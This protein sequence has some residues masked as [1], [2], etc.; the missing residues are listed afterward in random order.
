MHVQVDDVRLFFDTVGPGLR[1]DGAAM[2]AVP[3]VI[4]LHGG[5]GLDHSALRPALDVLGEISQVVYLDL[6][7]HGRSDR[8]SPEHWTLQRWADDLRGFCAALGIERPTVLGTSFGGYVAMMFALRYP[9][10]PARMILI[11]T[12]LRGTADPERQA[13]MLAAFARVGG[14]EPRRVA[15]R[16]FDQRTPEAFAEYLKVCGP[17][18]TRRPSDAE[19]SR[20][21]LGNPAL[22]PWFERPGGEGAVFNLRTA[23]AAV[24]CPTLVMG[25][26]DDPITP[27][28]EQQDIVAALP[29]G[30]GR[31]ARFAGCGHGVWRDDPEGA[32]RTIAGFLAEP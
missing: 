30:L 10:L 25:G 21:I 1:P 15:E 26:E 11:S 19:A 23:L 22:I 8:G 14:D 18:Y 29:P 17:C 16:V 13:R 2:R 9:E 32:Y 27:I 24:A 31:L 3:T 7:G 20:R 12:A 4:A 6:R 5:P 28:A